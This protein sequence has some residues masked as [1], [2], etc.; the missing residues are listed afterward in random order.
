MLVRMGL[1][2]TATG[3]ALGSAEILARLLAPPRGLVRLDQFTQVVTE[4]HK[5]HF[6]D[7]FVRDE[8]AFWR[9]APGVRLPDD[10]WPLPGLISNAQGVRE[11]HEIPDRKAASEIRILFLGDSCTFGYGVA[12]DASF[13]DVAEGMLRSEFPGVSI[14]CINAGVPGYTLFQGWR[15]LLGDGFD[16]Q[17]DLVVLQF[18]WNGLA[19]WDGIGD[20]QQYE[21]FRRASPPGPLRSSRLCQLLWWALLRPERPEAA[22]P[23]PRLLPD[24]FRTILQAIAEATAARGVDL[25]VLLWPST[26]N[27]QRGTLMPLQLEQVRFA[28]EH[29]IGPDAGPALIDAVAAMRDAALRYPPTAV[30]VDAIHMTALGQRVVA[31]AAARKIAPWVAARLRS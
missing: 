12:H 20:L 8:E 18:G 9:L 25:L 14:E 29:P 16:F 13:V 11:D 22:E 15:R 26:Q 1:A 6:E 5:M 31:E 24:E 23:R 7:V 19:E 3:V 28:E 4:R 27:V 10:A 17:P 30:Y 21:E 2:A